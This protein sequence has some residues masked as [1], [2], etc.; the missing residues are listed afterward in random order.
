MRKYG[1]YN[2]LLESKEENPTIPSLSQDDDSR[3]QGQD[4]LGYPL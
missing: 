4:F 3:R 2:N 1:C